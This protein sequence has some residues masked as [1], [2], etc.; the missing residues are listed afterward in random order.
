MQ[1]VLAEST[2]LACTVGTGIIPLCAAAAETWRRVEGHNG[3][4]MSRLAAASVRGLITA[5]VTAI[6]AGSGKARWCEL[7]TSDP[8]AVRPF[9]QVFPH[10]VVVCVHRGCLDM[11]RAGVAASPWGLQG[12]AFEPYLQPYHGNSVAALAA[13][14][15]NATGELL[16]FEDANPQITRRLRYEDATADPGEAVAALRAWL[17]LDGEP[18]AAFPGQFQ[19]A[20]PDQAAFASPQPEV[21]VEMIPPP[22]RQ[23]V[24]QLHDRLGYPPLSR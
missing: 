12:P 9:L 21:P 4:T 17:R 11:V 6:L 1:E 24:S 8:G 23:R 5:Q 7:A 3:Q 19:P 22:L 20:E 13:Y 10:A 14:W 15:A 16:A 18:G 2:G